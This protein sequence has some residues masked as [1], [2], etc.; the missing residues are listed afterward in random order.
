MAG[1]RPQCPRIRAG[2]GRDAVGLVL[3]AGAVGTWGSAER[4]AET[5]SVATRAVGAR[6]HHDRAEGRSGEVEIVLASGDRVRVAASVSADTLRR[7]VQAVRVS[8]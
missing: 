2:A 7:V 6:A 4:T 8:C 1:Q 5:S 3:L